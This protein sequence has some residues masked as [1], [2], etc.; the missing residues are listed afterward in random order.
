[1]LG[2]EW[3]WGWEGTE[4]RAA[5]PCSRSGQGRCWAASRHL[6]PS[7]TPEGRDWQRE[8]P[9]SKEVAINVMTQGREE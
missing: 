3:G 2:L 9:K 8:D 5:G 6:P 7:P 1:M 4:E